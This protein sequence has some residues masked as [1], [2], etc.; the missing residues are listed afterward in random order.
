M[1]KILRTLSGSLPFIFFTT[2]SQAQSPGIIVRPAGGP[3][4]TVLDPDQNGYTSLT[5]SGFT[6][7]DIGAAYSEINYIVVPPAITEPT[8]DLATGPS[9]GFS[10]IVRTVDGSGF[11]VYS[12]GTNICFRLR[13]GSIISG[14]KGYSILIDTDG[15][16][17]NTGPYADPDYV[18]P[19]NTSNGNPGFEYEVV[20]ETNFQVQVFNVNGTANP[21]SVATYSLNTNSQISVALSTDGSNPDYFYD[22]FVPLS[23][24]GSPSSIRMAATTVTSPNSALQGSRSD[25]YGIDDATSGVANGWI[26]VINA[27]PIINVTGSGIASVGTICT[28]APTLN[29]PITIGSSVS[30]PGTWTRMDV[31]KPS[32][33]TI[34]LYKNGSSVNTTTV[35]TGNTW[36]ITVPVVANGDV[37]YAKAQA[38]GESQCLQ[39]NTVTAGC[40]SNPIAPVVTCASTKGMSGTIPLGT[41]I[42]IYE[43]T[44]SNNAVTATPLTTGLVYVNNASDRTFN[45]Y[46]TNAQ[47][48][49]P[50]SGSAGI[51]TAGATLMFVTNNGGCLSI[52]VLG[53]VTGNNGTSTLTGLS[54]SSISLTTPIYPYQTTV[55]GTG[56]TSG[57]VLR[58]FVNDEYKAA[59]T[60]TGSSFSFTGI[61]LKSG[62]Q[63][64]VYSQTA[65]S[66][67][68]VS[69][70]TT[71][72][73]YTQPP[74]ITTN[75]AGNLLAGATSVSG[76]SAYAGATVTLYKGTSPS[77][78]SQG[79][80]LVNGSG[81]WTIT[82]S[83][84][85]G[86]DNYYATQTYSSCTSP[87]SSSTTVASVTTVCPIIT[88]SYTSGSTNVTGIL[89]SSFTGTV[90]LY[91]D[92]VQIGSTSVTSATTWSINSP[93]IYPLYP[94][95]ILTATTQ[96][97]GA[98]EKTDCV[99]SSTISCTSPTTPSI[100]SISPSTTISTGQTVQFTV[101]GVVSN[102]WYAIM[103]NA[104]ISY[105]NS[106]YTSNTNNLS[107]TT[108]TFTTQGAYSL[109]ISADQL[110]GCASART[111]ASILVNPITLPVTFINVSGKKE[112]N[113][114]RIS[115]TVANEQNV[116]HYEI[117][118]SLDGR[119]FDIAGKVFYQSNS[120]LSNSYGFIDGFAS[121]GRI[122]YR[123]K[124]VD[125]NG[126]YNYSNIISIA[127]NKIRTMISP[128][129]ANGQTTVYIDLDKEE[130][131]KILLMDL[132][133]KMILQK[134]VL[135]GMGSNA[136][137]LS[138]LNYHRRG[139]Y[140]VKLSTAEEICYLKL[141]LQ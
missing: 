5:T 81:A 93:F 62:D 91:L 132:N 65:G 116:D 39:S 46:G 117:E 3:Y 56:A 100:L 26:S 51:I 7:S 114:N 134:S 140:I 28:A 86:N 69:G 125:D 80:A 19:T 4:S 129:P 104:G 103:D 41:A 57:Q 66:C 61:T 54:S 68:T 12:N 99:T 95:G 11:Y 13:I 107:I 97:T 87:S 84:L 137:N 38:A 130:R 94:G 20:Y 122:Y 124:Q 1:K 89:G 131:V 76:N 59:V 48:G 90:R 101:S 33:A 17:G 64:K 72:S 108:R 24:V 123:V 9:G 36:T 135:L 138:N 78:V 15:K 49:N 85:T 118:R 77:G 63:L 83:A 8:G 136:V 113:Q 98:A 128:N 37:F 50:C 34:T 40:A 31:S 27:Q 119:S 60:A 21:V 105:A 45:Y 55:G 74:V 96:T 67:M 112:N 109:F 18:A 6:T 10:D 121:T 29:T 82:V 30:V 43:I 126:N 14:S 42:N 120:S 71:V 127:G 73:C 110:S 53:C 22:W 44:T 58:L 47:S 141:I 88:G 115:W 2:V 139:T 102:T 35:T 75:S 92:D 106:V 79:S 25:I 111:M 23:T 52:P 16:M 32:T 133:G 70:T